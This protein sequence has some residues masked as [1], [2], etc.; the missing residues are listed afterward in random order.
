LAPFAALSAEFPGWN[1][2][3]RKFDAL[4]DD[5]CAGNETAE[6]ELRDFWRRWRRELD[7][8]TVVRIRGAYE[9]RLLGR[10]SSLDGGAVERT[11]RLLT[12][13]AIYGALFLER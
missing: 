13:L 4:F 12:A 3:L 11:D 6:N 10:L 7:D 9:E 5:A 8:E 2:E 1:E